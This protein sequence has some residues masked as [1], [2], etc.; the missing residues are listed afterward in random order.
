MTSTNKATRYLERGYVFYSRLSENGIASDRDACTARRFTSWTSRNNTLYTAMQGDT[1]RALA[2]RFY[3]REDY[4][5]IIADV[6]FKI[7]AIQGA[8]GLNAGEIV[9]IP[10]R[11]FLT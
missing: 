10:P 5:W 8:F 3:G 4:W 2:L 9:E 1:F 11:S 6:N 7:S